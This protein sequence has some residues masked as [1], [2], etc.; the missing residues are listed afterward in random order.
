METGCSS[1]TKETKEE[2][3][4]NLDELLGLVNQLNT[5]SNGTKTL[6]I[7]RID[8]FLKGNFKTKKN[9]LLIKQ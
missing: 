8:P 7:F 2:L 9:E 5:N 3:K 1:S 4:E 6:S